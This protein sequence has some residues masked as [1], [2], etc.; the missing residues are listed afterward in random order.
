M[1]KIQDYDVSKVSKELQEFVDAMRLL[2]NFGKF[3]FQVINA[4]TG[5]TFAGRPG[6]VTWIRNG[7]DGRA[8]VYMGSSWNLALAFTADAS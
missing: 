3:Q 8:Y 5:P 2:V 6:E 4:S 7:T 1:A